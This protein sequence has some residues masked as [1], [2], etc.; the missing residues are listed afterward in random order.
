MRGLRIQS[1][2]TE[3]AQE[4][5]DAL[6]APQTHPRAGTAPIAR[7]MWRPGRIYSRSY[8]P[9]PQ[10]TGQTEAHR[11]CRRVEKRRSCEL[12]QEI[13]SISL[14]VPPATR[15]FSTESAQIGRSLHMQARQV[16]L[17]EADLQLSAK[18]RFRSSLRR[19]GQS[20]MCPFFFA[21]QSFRRRAPNP[22]NGYWLLG[23]NGRRNTGIQSRRTFEL[24]GG[25]FLMAMPHQFS[26]SAELVRAF[27][28]IPTSLVPELDAVSEIVTLSPT[29]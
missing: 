18:P 29:T 16:L 8:R 11:A 15:C 19:L 24:R 9:E 13:R 6:R 23:R 26:I 12:L 5:G 27:K 3:A 25:R 21:L 10:E 2:G 14:G 22:A 28:P 20:P 1:D 4:G 7:A 17:P